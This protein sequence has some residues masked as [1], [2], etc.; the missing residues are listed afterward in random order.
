MPAK[1]QVAMIVLREPQFGAIE[2]LQSALEADGGEFP[3]VEV[4]RE[5][6][7]ISFHLGEDKI[8]VSSMKTPIP[9]SDLKGPC[10]AA[11]YWPEAAGQL[12]RHAAHILVVVVPGTPDRKA[13]AIKLTKVAAAL[14]ESSPAAGV[15]WGGSGTVH[16]P[17]PFCQTAAETAAD[18]LPVEIWIGFGLIPEA[19]ETHSVFTSGL[20]DFGMQEIEIHSS[21]RDP[22]FLYERLFDVVHYVL[23]KDVVLHDGETIGIS[24]TERITIQQTQSLCDG[25]TNVLQLDM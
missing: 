20:E 9:W 25:E 3:P 8:V 19:N 1:S 13:A 22:Q 17:Q 6:N 5:D 24:D 10:S 15:L 2:K 21:Q 16:A 14:V 11:W 23:R 18:R 12:R 7:T 4:Q